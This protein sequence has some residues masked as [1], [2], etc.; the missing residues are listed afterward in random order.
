M[1]TRIFMNERDAEPID[2]PQP[3]VERFPIRVDG[4]SQLQQLHQT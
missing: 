2:L 1:E 3:H 4:P